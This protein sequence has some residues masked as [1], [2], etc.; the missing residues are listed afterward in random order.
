MEKEYRYL[1]A[2]K[3]SEKIY[4]AVEKDTYNEIKVVEYLLQENYS[5][6]PITEG[7]Y[8]KLSEESGYEEIEL[9]K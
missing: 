4:L 1:I 3:G 2:I 6:K 5:L 8:E 7:E 9:S